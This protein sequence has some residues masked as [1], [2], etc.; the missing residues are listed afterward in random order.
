MNKILSLLG[1]MFI[2]LKLTN[3]IGWN[4]WLVLS[5]FL[6]IVLYYSILVSLYLYAAHL[7]NKKLETR[8][9][10]RKKVNLRR[11]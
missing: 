9:K 11:F 5:P 1:L 2:G 10:Y 6:F 7:E 3:F 4:W 8:N